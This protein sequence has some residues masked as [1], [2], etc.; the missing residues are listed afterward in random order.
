M[1]VRILAFV[2][3]QA[4]RIPSASHY[5]VICDL[6]GPTMFSHYLITVMIFGG[7]LMNITCVLLSLQLLSETFLILRRT[8]RDIII[9]VYWSSRKVP[10]ILTRF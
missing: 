10:V 6:S 2:I 7:G 4:N 9:N 5:A 1:C 3:R 8:D